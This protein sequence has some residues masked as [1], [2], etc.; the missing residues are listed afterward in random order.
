MSGSS[1]ADR[2]AAAL[3]TVLG[4]DVLP[5][6]LR[7]WDG[8]EAGPADAPVVAFRSPTAVRRLV[9][10]PGELGLVRAY[11]AGDLD[12][13]GDVYDTLGALAPV[14]RGASSDAFARPSPRQWAG[15]AE[16]ITIRVQDYRTVDDGPFDAVASVG[17]AEHVGRAA[18]PRYVRALHDVL[19]PGGRLLHHVIAWSAGETTW[20][21]DTFIARYVF[22]D[23][24][25]ISLADTV[26]ALEESFEVLDV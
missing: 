5:W 19:A 23:G 10:A 16:R 21:D 8:S 20:D 26:A 14:T 22:P 25:L 18:L 2:L 3:G 7:A 6:R 11:V 24:E 17:M 15:L 9:W 1:V 13:E 12:L 4:T